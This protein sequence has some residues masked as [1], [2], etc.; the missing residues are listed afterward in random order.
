M[1][2][3]PLVAAAEQTV[4]RRRTV[5]PAAA[6]PDRLCCQQARCAA[7]LLQCIAAPAE[8]RMRCSGAQSAALKCGT[9]RLLAWR[10]VRPAGTQCA[11]CQAY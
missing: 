9:Q 10:C 2:A 11:D 4:A 1:S 5:R 8:V 7:T 3:L 6:L